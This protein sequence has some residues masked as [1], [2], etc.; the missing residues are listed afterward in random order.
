MTFID[1][2]SSR[3]RRIY[4]SKWGFPAF[5]LLAGFLTMLYPLTQLG[6]YWDD[7]EVV[8]LTR[9]A[10]PAILEGYFF[11]DRPLAWPYPIF[12]SLLGAQPFAWHLLTLLLRWAGTL[13][14]YQ[15]LLV[16]WPGRRSAPAVG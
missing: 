13:C 12:A 11:F 2:L 10:N 1:S 9:L 15:A 7:W 5:L 4:Q 14:F 16:L 8:Y 3:A 6:Y